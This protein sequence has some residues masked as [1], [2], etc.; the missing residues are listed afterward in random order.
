MEMAKACPRLARPRRS[1]GTMGNNRP[2]SGI[3]RGNGGGYGNRKWL[4]L[5]ECVSWLYTS[6]PLHGPNTESRRRRVSIFRCLTCDFVERTYPLCPA[7][8]MENVPLSKGGLPKRE[9]FWCVNDND[10]PINV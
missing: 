1:G 2:W 8:D 6:V 4:R 10:K 5:I 3:R 7:R 9:I